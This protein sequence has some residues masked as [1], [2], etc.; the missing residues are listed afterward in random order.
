M[1][2]SSFL[3]S[4]SVGT[5]LTQIGNKINA[6]GLVDAMGFELQ[7]GSGHA[8][9][10]FQLVAQFHPTG[11]SWTIL[12]AADWANIIAGSIPLPNF[13]T[14]VGSVSP[15]TL[16]LSTATWFIL[17]PLGFYQFWFMAQTA[18]ST[19]NLTVVGIGRNA[20]E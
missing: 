20:R 4:A 12:A 19:T 10:D 16:A 6:N 17:R 8:L 13:L 14:A 7:N 2:T 18:S 15:G 11:A 9:S 3:G 5:S 1:Q